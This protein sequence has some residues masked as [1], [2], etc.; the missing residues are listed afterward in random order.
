MSSRCMRTIIGLSIAFGLC[1]TLVPPAAHAQV[2]SQ[3]TTSG[4]PEWAVVPDVYG[5][6]RDFLLAVYPEFKNDHH[7]FN[8]DSL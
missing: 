1:I 5:M 6:F 4:Q 8:D 2:Q 7:E 3:P